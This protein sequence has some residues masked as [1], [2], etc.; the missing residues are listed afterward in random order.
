MSCGKCVLGSYFFLYHKSITIKVSWA[1]QDLAC[2]PETVNVSLFIETV[3]PL[4][5]RSAMQY[6]AT[7]SMPGRKSNHGLTMVST[8]SASRWSRPQSQILS[9]LC[10]LLMLVS[11]GP[12]VAQLERYSLVLALCD[13]FS[14]F[15]QIIDSLFLCDNV[16]IS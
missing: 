6:I 16:C 10:W 15:H 4:H 14:L 11:A 5:W 3:L 2:T 9:S 12:T 1:G 7:V 13:P 8:L